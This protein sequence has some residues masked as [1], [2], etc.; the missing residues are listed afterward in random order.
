MTLGSTDTLSADLVYGTITAQLADGSGQITVYPEEIAAIK[1]FSDGTMWL[2]IKGVAGPFA[3]AAPYEKFR[4]F[5]HNAR[6][7]LT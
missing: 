6:G 1:G 3:L 7:E 5:W 2:Y 4:A